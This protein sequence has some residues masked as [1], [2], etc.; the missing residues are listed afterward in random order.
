MPYLTL[1]G[2][3]LTLR[4]TSS[5]LMDQIILTFCTNGSLSSATDGASKV[6]FDPVALPERSTSTMTMAPASAIAANT[7]QPLRPLVRNSE[8]ASV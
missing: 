2:A 8:A 7:A 5:F 3:K 1:V 6:R 4:T